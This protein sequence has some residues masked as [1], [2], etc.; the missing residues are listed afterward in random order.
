[1]SMRAC[2]CIKFGIKK[3]LRYKANTYSWFLAD[4]SLYM[5]LIFM[6][7]LLSSAFDSFAS[8]SK[9]E[10]G[11][12]IST[13][14]IINNLFAVLFSQAVS[15]YNS[16]VLDGTFSYY[17]LTP[18]GPLN[19][20]VLLNFN[21]PALLSTPFLLAINIYFVVQLVTFPVRIFLYYLGVIFACG[22]MFFVFQSISA[23]LLFGLRSS[24]IN[25]AMTQLFSIAEKPD[26]V[27]HPT[28]RKIFTFVIPAFVFS[29]IPSKVIFGTI[30]VMEMLYLFLSPVFFFCVYQVL[31]S[32]GCRFYQHSGF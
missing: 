32:V 13:Y 22:T 21:F 30:S 2:A 31:E 12:Y 11:L 7:V 28:F 18:I 23:L 14:F 9:K 26:A 27:F 4:V 25:S 16:C 19:S 6:Y 15:A 5:S 3:G 29:A 10:L 17:Q 24:A 20:L 8:Y 1:M